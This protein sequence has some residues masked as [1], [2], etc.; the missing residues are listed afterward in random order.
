MHLAASTLEADVEAALA[1]LLADQKPITDEAVKLLVKARA[2]IE[3]PD[4]VAPR[5]DLAAYDALLQVGS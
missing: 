2:T 1:L 5:V 4:L 3:V